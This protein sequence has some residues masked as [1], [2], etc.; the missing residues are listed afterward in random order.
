MHNKDPRSSQRSARLDHEGAKR[1]A[2]CSYR[3][4]LGIESESNRKA[5]QVFTWVCDLAICAFLRYIACCGECIRSVLEWIWRSQVGS[6]DSNPGK[7][8]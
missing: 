1:E 2:A 8:G 3:D 4:E 7:R 5:L 6:S